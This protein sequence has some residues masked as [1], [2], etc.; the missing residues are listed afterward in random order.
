MGCTGSKLRC[1]RA[2]RKKH[3]KAN[4][5]VKQLNDIAADHNGQNIKEYDQQIRDILH[6]HEEEKTEV[7]YAHK[8]EMEARILDL[9]EQ[10]RK[11]TDAEIQKRLSE[12][13]A[14]MKLEMDEKCGELQRSCDEKTLLVETYEKL[15][16]SLKESLEELNSKVAQFE[17]T[18]K[19]VEKSVLN[20]DYK[21]HI[22]DHGSP[23]QFWEQ[24]LQ[25]LHFVIEMKSELI[26]EQEKKL[27]ICEATMDRNFTLEERV[28][29][30]QQENEALREQ[31]QKQTA[32]TIRLSEELLKAQVALEKE[33]QVREQLQRDKEQ[34]LYREMNGDV[35]PKFS[36]PTNTQNVPL[37][38]T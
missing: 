9:Q 17:E 7:A 4:P 35:P 5:E 13:A 14:N 15:I 8:A 1:P 28:R 37:I 24:E 25:S 2:R 23:G 16:A 18:M 30:L 12:Q 33:I 19:R 26:R 6:K 11:D 38:V 10:A 20:Q 36:L 34:H 31:T 22:Q 3:S 29:S 21:R 32:A 27:L